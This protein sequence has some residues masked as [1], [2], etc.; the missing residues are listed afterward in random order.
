MPE[1]VP[2]VGT[3]PVWPQKFRLYPR[4]REP[5]SNS[6][7]PFFNWGVS[8]SRRPRLTAATS[9]SLGS[10]NTSLSN[11]V[12]DNTNRTFVNNGAFLRS[13]CS[14]WKAK[15]IIILTGTTTNG[16]PCAQRAL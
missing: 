2:K 3:T 1:Q 11:F 16:N 13:R 8:Y 9:G 5:G 10:I 6:V 14:L 12:A 15:A 7:M 4:H